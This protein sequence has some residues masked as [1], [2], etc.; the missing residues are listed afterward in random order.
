MIGMARRMSVQRKI[1]RWMLGFMILSLRC[2]DSKCVVESAVFMI[3]SSRVID[4]LQFMNFESPEMAIVE[5]Q[6]RTALRTRRS[7]AASRETSPPR[8]QRYGRW[9]FRRE[10]DPEHPKQCATRQHPLR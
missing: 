8:H 2:I 4:A 9:E 6:R 10:N 1:E 7:I 5:F 3:A